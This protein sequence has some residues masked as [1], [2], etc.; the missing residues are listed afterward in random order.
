VF[1]LPVPPEEDAQ[2]TFEP[3]FWIIDGLAGD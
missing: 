2:V 3:C 1:A